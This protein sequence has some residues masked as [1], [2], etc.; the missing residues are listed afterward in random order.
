MSHLPSVSSSFDLGMYDV[1]GG[2]S[3][4][5][6]SSDSNYFEGLPIIASLRKA[7]ESSG[8][9]YWTSRGPQWRDTKGSSFDQSNSIVGGIKTLANWTLDGLKD[10]V[11]FKEVA[12]VVSA[13]PVIRKSITK[14]LVLSVAVVLLIFFFE[15][16]F[17]PTQLFLRHK[18]VDEDEL[19]AIGNG[20]VLWL[21]PVIAISYFVASS[22][23]L[24]VAQAAYK[25]RNNHLRGLSLAN[26]TNPSSTSSL[27]R[28]VCQE[29]FRVFLILNYIAVV[30]ALQRLPYTWISRMASFL[31]MSFVDAFYCFE[32][33]MTSRGWS[34][35]R[36]MRFVEER[37][38]YMTAF[39]ILPTLVSFF[40]PSGLLNLF[41][42]MLVYPFYTVLALMANPQPR[43]NSGSAGPLVP[44]RLPFFFPTA[45]CY[46]WVMKFA[47]DS[48]ADH[49][50]AP[51]GYGGITRSYSGANG[52][53]AYDSKHS[54]WNS[55]PAW[56]NYHGATP[57]GAPGI[58]ASF[59]GQNQ[60]ASLG[61]TNEFT[62]PSQSSQTASS[63]GPVAGRR[64]AA[65]FVG[66]VWGNNQNVGTMGSMRSNRW[67]GSTPTPPQSPSP[68]SIDI[69][70]NSNASTHTS[71]PTSAPAQELSSFAPAQF[72]PVKRTGGQG[73]PVPSISVTSASSANVSLDS[74]GPM[75]WSAAGVKRGGKKMD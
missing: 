41:L 72:S 47:P 21:Y 55:R 45:M 15:L 50:D 36:K 29:S 63:L 9:A 60:Q 10:S 42:F 26:I 20:N 16:A 62:H 74:A 30:L 3:S 46:R 59:Q 48:S 11:K 5:S 22:W 65:Q 6:L 58:P 7:E 24:D 49:D 53:G 37:W 69:V 31:F 4:T 40:H 43:N 56:N 19:T 66:G 25:L 18:I 52:F 12:G 67:G 75:P 27:R 68:V 57:N 44:R 73:A 8:V 35:E 71:A 70:S 2:S 61:A 51:L 14:G 17:F 33:V 64:T 54:G 38:A 34:I 1:E 28:K 39:G 23:T 13:S 32:P